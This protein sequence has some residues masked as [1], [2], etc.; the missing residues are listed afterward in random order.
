M[1]VSVAL[2]LAACSDDPDGPE[3][4][5][6]LW[7]ELGIVSYEIDLAISC[8]CPTPHLVTVAV[9]N[10]VIVGVTDLETG[11]QLDASQFARFYTVEQLFN[12]IERAEREADQFEV[13]YHGELHHPTS[14]DI[15][16]IENAIDD[17]LAV[18]ASGL[19]S[20]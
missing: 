4:Q 11:D 14:I 9:E 6:A 15:D 3:D 1:C 12:L 20:G 7:R 19:T 10:D 8:F 5:R 16:W 18:Q 13:E 17:E 2:G